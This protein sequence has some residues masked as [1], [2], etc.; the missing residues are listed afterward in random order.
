MSP[1]RSRQ[2]LQEEEIRKRLLYRRLQTLPYGQVLTLLEMLFKEPY[3]RFAL[4]EVIR[5]ALLDYEALLGL[6]GRERVEALRELADRGGLRCSLFLSPI[7]SHS[8]DL[9]GYVEEEEAPMEYVPLG[10]RITMAKGSDFDTLSRLLPDPDPKVIKALLDNPRITEREV[11]RIAS[12]RPNTRRVLEAISLH[13]RWMHRYGVRKALA[14][15]PH[16]P[17][18]TSIVILTGLLDRDLR[19]IVEDPTLHP[20]VRGVA[21]GMVGA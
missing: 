5:E 10:E 12:R 8:K 16:T 14:C 6:M 7:P 2:A 9:A 11:I 20:L 1:L 4:A 15:N 21:A 18:R 13:R 19:L 3:R 17:P